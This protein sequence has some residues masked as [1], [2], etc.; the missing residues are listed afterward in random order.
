M[1]VSD[2]LLGWNTNVC[3]QNVYE[4]I[5]ILTDYHRLLVSLVLDPLLLITH[6][7]PQRLDSVQIN[8]CE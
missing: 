4:A 5:F 3:V 6:L 2:Q 8:I 1:S 7:F